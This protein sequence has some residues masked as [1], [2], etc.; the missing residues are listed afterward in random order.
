LVLV[1]GRWK[2]MAVDSRVTYQDG[3][4]AYQGDI[5]LPDPGDPRIVMT[6]RRTYWW[7]QPG[8]LRIA[9]EPT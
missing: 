6:Y 5:H 2:W 9:Q 1:D 8:R 4:V 3:R 7:P